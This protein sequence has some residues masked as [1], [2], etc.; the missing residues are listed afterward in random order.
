MN[1]VLSDTLNKSWAYAAALCNILEVDEK[2]QK[3]TKA[4]RLLHEQLTQTAITA[5]PAAFHFSGSIYM[6]SW[7]ILQDQ[8][9]EKAKLSFI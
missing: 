6:N 8:L 2:V 9:T 5:P 1:L 4:T 3:I 7:E